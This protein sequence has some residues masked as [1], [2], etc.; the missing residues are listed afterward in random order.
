VI[1]AVFL[2]RLRHPMTPKGEIKRVLGSGRARVLAR[3]VR[4]F[5]IAGDVEKN[6][7]GL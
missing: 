2:M 3:P 4:D 7:A 5:R 1:Q 6:T